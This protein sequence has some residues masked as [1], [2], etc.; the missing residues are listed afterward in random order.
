M[1]FQYFGIARG[2]KDGEATIAH[3][4]AVRTI[5]KQGNTLKEGRIERESSY[6]D[7]NYDWKKDTWDALTDGMYGDYPEDGSDIDDL[8]ER[9]GLD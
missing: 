6:H 4:Y 9:L 8:M 7:D 5:D 2:F 3:D 1:Q